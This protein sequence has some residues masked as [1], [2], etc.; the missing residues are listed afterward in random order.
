M[1]RGGVKRVDEAIKMSGY[2][3]SQFHLWLKQGAYERK[4]RERKVVCEQTIEAAIDVI[5]TFPHFSGVK[6]QMY[7]VY[8][9]LGFIPQHFYKELKRMVR[10]L[11]FQ[12]VSTQNLL[13]ER[14]SY[15]H[16][17]A[18]KPG[19]IWAEDFTQIMV[20]DHRYYI[21]LIMD[22]NS[23]HYLGV[24]S[25]TR[26]GKQFVALPLD[27][28]VTQNKGKGPKKYLL[29]DNGKQYIDKTHES[30]LEMLDI[31]HKKIP[32]CTPQYNGT[33]ECGVK[34]FK[35]V[36]YPLFARMEQEKDADKKR[37]TLNTSCQN[38]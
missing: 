10:R 25:S 29:S 9:R 19:E 16:E 4:E 34:E 15:T 5:K 14:T 2:S 1:S 28:A 22:V 20:Y 27:Q 17:R 32:A 8:H 13:P 21:A 31:I 36:F 23:L 38:C 35:N 33:V 30:H 18:E 12:E 37:K 24:S 7:M 11:V 6:G 26:A 3:Y